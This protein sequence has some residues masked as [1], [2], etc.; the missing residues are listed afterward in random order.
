MAE[1]DLLEVRSEGPNDG[2]WSL[3]QLGCGQIDEGYAEMRLVEGVN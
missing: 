1:M 2:E 3:L